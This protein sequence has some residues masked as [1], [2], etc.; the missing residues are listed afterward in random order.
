[1]PFDPFLSD[2]DYAILIEARID[3]LCNRLNLPKQ[4][5]VDVDFDGSLAIYGG[6]FPFLVDSLLDRLPE[7]CAVA[8]ITT[9]CSQ[10][11]IYRGYGVLA[12][13]GSTTAGILDSAEV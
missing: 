12:W 8:R 4:C 5:H 11:A 2:E 6:A 9:G 7:V 1:M 10:L 3:R 13:E